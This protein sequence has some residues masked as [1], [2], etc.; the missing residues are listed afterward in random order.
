MVFIFLA[1]DCFM[2]KDFAK[3]VALSVIS[4]MV[5]GG[6]VVEA[7][8]FRRFGGESANYSDS[9]IKANVD[10]EVCKKETKELKEK[11][12]SLD[13]R[14][15][16]LEKEVKEHKTN[17]YHGYGLGNGGWWKNVL[18]NFQASLVCAAFILP[19]AMICSASDEQFE[20]KVE[21]RARK[22]AMRY[23]Q[24]YK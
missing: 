17:D 6:A 10:S 1:G 14:L 23:I 13:E 5:S 12:K 7:A 8:E 22:L 20:E 4:G 24:R 16:A 18:S 19:V 2:K 21:A 9:V 15:T 3:F 11:N